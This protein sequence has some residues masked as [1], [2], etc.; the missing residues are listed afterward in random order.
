MINTTASL[1]TSLSVIGG[2]VIFAWK[3][4]KKLNDIMGG[5]KSMERDRI[6]ATY[7]KHVDEGEP[8]LRQ[9]ERD[10]LDKLYE[11]YI[12]LGG[13]SFIQDIYAQMRHWKVD[14]G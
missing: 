3:V 13:N 7:Y 11:S 6:T 5:V 14:K 10:S 2:A 9:Y 1:I 4:L 12:T 8:S